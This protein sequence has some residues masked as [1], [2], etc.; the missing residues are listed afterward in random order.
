LEHGPL[1]CSSSVLQT[2][3]HGDIVECAKGGNEGVGMLFSLLH[4]DLVI[5]QVCIQE[6][7]KL[8][9][10]NRVYDL[11]N[12]HE[13]ERVLG[14]CLIEPCVVGTHPL[15]LVLLLN[16]HTICDPHWVVYFL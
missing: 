10:D 1:V 8:T 11:I 4:G 9:P 6:G 3:W 13:M 15:A 2:E 16:E 5:A 12:S 7:K 14:A